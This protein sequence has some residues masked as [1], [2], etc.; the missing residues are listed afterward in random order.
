MLY[1]HIF[2]HGTSLN[3]VIYHI[4]S[5]DGKR[6]NIDQLLKGP[7]KFIWGHVLDNN[8]GRLSGGVSGFLGT[9]TISFILKSEI[10]RDKKITFA[11][12]VYDEKLLKQDKIVS[13]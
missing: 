4:F 6:Q 12:M 9:K 1:K 3:E 8:L 7:M 5:D 11:N 13:D 2:P 10:P